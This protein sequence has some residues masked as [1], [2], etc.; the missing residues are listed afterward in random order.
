MKKLLAVIF[1]IGTVG[2]MYRASGQSYA[3]RSMGPIA[4]AVANCPLAITPT[5]TP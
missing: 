2:L 1:L 4:P 3:S 5:F